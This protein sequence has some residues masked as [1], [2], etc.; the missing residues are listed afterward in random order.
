MYLIDE[1]EDLTMFR[2]IEEFLTNWS[3]ESESTQ[4][5]LDALTD[6]SLA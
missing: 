3:H 4:K 5:V 6:A 1:L 2:T